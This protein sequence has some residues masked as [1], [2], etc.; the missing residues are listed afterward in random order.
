MVSLEMLFIIMSGDEY[1]IDV[2]EE[3]DGDSTEESEW[4]EEEDYWEAWGVQQPKSQRKSKRKENF[5]TDYDTVE[6]HRRCTICPQ[7]RL[8]NRLQRVPIVEVRDLP[9]HRPGE[10]QEI[11]SVLLPTGRRP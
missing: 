2:D 9:P 6:S 4:E 10:R 8:R 5:V 3:G 7:L 1:P 11:Q